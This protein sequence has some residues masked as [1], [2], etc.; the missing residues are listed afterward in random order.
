MVPKQRYAQKCG[1]KTKISRSHK[2]FCLTSTSKE[3]DQRYNKNR[4]AKESDDDFCSPNPLRSLLAAPRGRYRRHEK[5]EMHFRYCTL[6]CES[7][8]G[9]VDSLQESSGKFDTCAVCSKNISH[10]DNLRK[11]AHVNRCLDTQESSNAYE[12]AK[13]K[14]NNVVDCPMCG[15][16]QPPGPHRSAHAKRCGKAFNITPKELL[17]LMETQQRICNAKK[18]HNMVHTKAPVP[19]KKE[20][21]PAKLKGAPNSPFEEDLQLA[22]ALSTSMITKANDENCDTSPQIKRYIFV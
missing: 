3:A 14:W 18:H 7:V 11:C 13:D 19:V 1:K 4:M 21:L 6:L 12:K 15:E 22:R 17:K 10:L 5:K 9:I 20:V 16:P 8:N 2:H